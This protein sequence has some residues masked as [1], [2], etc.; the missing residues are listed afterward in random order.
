MK[1]MVLFCLFF[2]AIFVY[3]QSNNKIRIYRTAEELR[4]SVK[5]TLFATN[6]HHE[7]LDTVIAVTKIDGSRIRIGNIWGYIDVDGKI[8]R[9]HSTRFIC[10]EGEADGFCLYSKGTG[11]KGTY[12]INDVRQAGG[13]GT[14]GQKYSSKSE[15][16]FFSRS[17]DSKIYRFKKHRLKRQYED[18]PCFPEKLNQIKRNFLG[19]YSF[20][21]SAITPKKM[22]EI[23]N[24]CK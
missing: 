24:S 23:Y 19:S 2:S 7:A 16:Y 5:D 12:G 3:A 11:G 22:I 14:F 18:K 9:N 21:V 1:N 17:L 6:V 15:S 10:L 4:S 8:Y 20:I 13:V